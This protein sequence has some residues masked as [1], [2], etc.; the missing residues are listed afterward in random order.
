VG[1]SSASIPAK[2]FVITAI[3][4]VRCHQEMKQP[5]SP[6]R[7]DLPILASKDQIKGEH[8]SYLT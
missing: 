3:M 8:N 1:A 2:F 6:A 5:I 7:S 4:P